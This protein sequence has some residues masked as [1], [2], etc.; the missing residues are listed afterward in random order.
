MNQRDRLGGPGATPKGATGTPH[1]SGLGNTQ[2]SRPPTTPDERRRERD[3]TAEQ[4]RQL[5]HRL[6][7]PR[8]HTDDQGE[9]TWT[10]E[11]RFGS[12]GAPLGERV[13]L[14][15]SEAQHGDGHRG[16]FNGIET[17]GS[18]TACLRCGAKVRAERG[19][20]CGEVIRLHL[21]NGGYALLL[22]LTMSHDN[23]ESA[24]QSLDDA[25]NAWSSMVETRN[26]KKTMAWLDLEGWIRSTETTWSETNGFHPHHHVPILVN[27]PVGL[28]E[29]YPEEL[30]EIRREFDEAWFTAVSKLGRDV[31]PDIGVD[32]VPIRDEEG[33]GA[34]VSKIEFEVAREDLKTGRG[35]SRSTWQIGVDAAEGCERSAA[36]W[37]EYVE[38]IKGR[39]WMSTSKGLWKKFGISV[40][41]DEEIAEDQPDVVEPVALVDADVYRAAAKT[42]DRQVLTE[43]RHLAE[44]NVAPFILALVL[45]RRL[46]RD[47]EIEYRTEDQD[48]PTLTWAQQW[49]TNDR[50]AGQRSRQRDGPPVLTRR[51]RNTGRSIEARGGDFDGGKARVHGS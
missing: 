3:R 32:L 45:S 33:I 50:L 7:G 11:H 15:R 30:E 26:W 43:L 36:L 48:V 46:N 49:W 28:N 19:C 24:G 18:S 1:T 22:T 16:V 8:V 23:Q 4:V 29:D 14:G 25:I 44:A 5:N 2:T 13:M 6:F 42:N 40:R 20:Q 34:Y 47:V 51:R 10:Q 38:A 12:C 31:H 27:R 9:Q 37:A 17:C 21:A 35:E 39:R 41:S